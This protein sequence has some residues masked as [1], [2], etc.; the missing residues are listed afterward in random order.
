[1]DTAVSQQGV[2]NVQMCHPV[3]TCCLRA[4]TR[5]AVASAISAALGRGGSGAGTV[6]GA[7]CC[8]CFGACL[9]KSLADKVW[10]LE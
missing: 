5:A 6:K 4:L 3:P 1:M 8:C 2:F 7:G 9:E 10:S